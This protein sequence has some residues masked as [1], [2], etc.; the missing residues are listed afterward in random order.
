[1][2]AIGGLL[3]DIDGVL[4]V[5]WEPIPGAAKTLRWLRDREIPFALVT[6]TTTMSRRG[7]AAR[8]ANVG[9]DVEPERLVT[10]PAATAA[11]VRSHHPGAR[12]FLLAKGDVAEDLKGIELV[13]ERADVVI[14]AGAE[15]ALTYEAMNHAFRMLRDGAALVAMH[16]NV[17]WMT[18]EGPKLD[19]GPYVT[20]LEE[21]AGVRAAVV[22]KPSPEIFREAVSLLG[23]ERDRAAMVGDDPE[24]DL[25]PAQSLGL[26]AILVR[27]GKFQA[28]TEAAGGARPDHV[29]DSVAELPEL[30]G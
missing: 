28:E 15:E 11:Y 6:N 29:I 7:L 18:S 17:W 1:M 2:A 20:A 9:L 23:V 8:L 30:L 4:V 14:M 24:A 5:S 22:G 26:T 13:D 21:A 10:A 19:A 25:A 3:L 16:R 12:C 27:T